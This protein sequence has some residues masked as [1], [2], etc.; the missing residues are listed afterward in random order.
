MGDR[1]RLDWTVH[2]AIS[3]TI[4]ITGISRWEDVG[5]SENVNKIFHSQYVVAIPHGNSILSAIIDA[6]TKTSICLFHTKAIS[7]KNFLT[8]SATFLLLFCRRL[9]CPTVVDGVQHNRECVNRE[10]LFWLLN[11]VHCFGYLAG[12]YIQYCCLFQHQVF[13]L[14]PVIVLRSSKIELYFPIDVFFLLVARHYELI[15]QKLLLLILPFF[16]NSHRIEGM[17]L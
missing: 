17:F 5:C 3:L 9:L 12:V 6:N 13:N 7:K 4:S 8:R 14:L 2:V 16:V 10:L 15:L 1:S 11:T